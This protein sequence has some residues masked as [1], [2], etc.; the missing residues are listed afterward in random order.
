MRSIQQMHKFLFFLTSHF[1]MLLQLNLAI[2]IA[3]SAMNN[4]LPYTVEYTEILSAARWIQL[5]AALA[6]TRNNSTNNCSIVNLRML[7]CLFVYALCWACVSWFFQLF[8]CLFFLMLLP[9][10]GF[11]SLLSQNALSI[12]VIGSFRYSC[13]CFCYIFH[14]CT[15]HTGFWPLL[16]LFLLLLLL[17]FVFARCWLIVVDAIADADGHLLISST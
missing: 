6:Y 9:T 7:V 13:C 15:L 5:H 17:S 4:V 2:H 12:V 16:L 1:H 10:N 14:Y 3:Q 8:V 11:C